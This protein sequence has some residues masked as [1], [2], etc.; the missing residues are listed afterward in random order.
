MQ[1]IVYVTSETLEHKHTHF[2]NQSIKNQLKKYRF[3]APRYWMDWVTWKSQIIVYFIYNSRIISSTDV[4]FSSESFVTKERKGRTRCQR[5]IT[6]NRQPINPQPMSTRV[7]RKAITTFGTPE[8][9]RCLRTPLLIFLSIWHTSA[10][11]ET[12]LRIV[13]IR[14]PGSF[15]LTDHSM[16]VLNIGLLLT[17]TNSWAVFGVFALVWQVLR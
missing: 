9:K 10:I 11:L 1:P 6:F 16:E 5:G 3:L 2:S 12:A 15:L 13:R 7:F 17:N 4:F 14:F 8:N